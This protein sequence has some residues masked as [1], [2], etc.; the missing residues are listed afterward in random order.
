MASDGLLAARTYLQQSRSLREALGIARATQLE[1]RPLGQGEHN[2]NFTFEHPESG[3][4]LVLRINYASQMNLENQIE[5]EAS[6]LRV[7]ESSARTPR[8]LFVDGSKRVVD[9]GVL[10][11]EH[12]QGSHLDFD[13]PGDVAEAAR[14]LADVHAVVPDEAPECPLIDPGDALRDLYEEDMR[15]FEA[16]CASPLADAALARRIES[17]FS[18]AEPLV[19]HVQA[20]LGRH[21]L[22]TEAV[23]SHFLIPHDGEPGSMVDWEKPIIGDVARDIAYFTALTTTIWDTEFLFDAAGR[24]AFVEQYWRAVDGRFPRTGFDERFDA[25]LKMNCLRGMTWSMLAWTEYHDPM[26]P[27]Q[28]EKTRKKLDVYLS[29][30]FVDL[31]ARD[32]FGLA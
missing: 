11:M 16:Y 9:H 3:E 17:F 22:N 28:N 25:Y 10:V 31:L 27:L 26:R 19:A 15:M 23:P 29:E 7:L 24:E 6:A 1:P 8:L 2:A 12:R 4:T 14:I 5:Y 13:K 21:V 20:P 32:I 18:A 30:P